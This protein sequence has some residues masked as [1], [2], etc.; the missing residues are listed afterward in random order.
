[1][2]ELPKVLKPR[3][4]REGG[5]RWFQVAVALSMVVSAVASLIVAWRTSETMKG[6]VEQNARLVRAGSTPILE[7]GHGNASSDNRSRL[8][9]NVRNVGTGPARLVW[10]EL[11]HEGKPLPDMGTLLREV[12]GKDLRVNYMTSPIAPRILPAG[13]D[14]RIF[15][16]AR[17]EESNTEALE[18]WSRIDRR[19]RWRLKIEGCFC[20]VFDECWTS[21]LNGQPP[22]PVP[23]CNEA[24]RVSP[25]G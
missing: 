25:A 12:G 10:L 9:F 2:I 19:A 6:L 1:M 13:S 8:E 22:T 15:A 16:W 7:F 11:R 17:P 5:P 20:S 14:T 21:E 3:D 23:D 24:G 4:G 18:V